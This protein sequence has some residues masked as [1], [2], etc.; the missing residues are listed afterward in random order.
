[1]HT[2]TLGVERDSAGVNSVSRAAVFLSYYSWD[3]SPLP[4]DDNDDNNNNGSHAPS[5]FP[6][7]S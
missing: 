5:V 6:L 7:R 2:R 4:D 1:M 3:F